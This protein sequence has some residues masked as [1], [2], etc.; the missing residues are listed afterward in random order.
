VELIAPDAGKPAKRLVKALTNLQDGLG[1]YQD[2]NIARGVLRGL[3]ADSFHFGVLY[4]RQEQVGRE[5]LAGVPALAK[6]ARRR[7]VRRVF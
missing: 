7:R 3:G 6:A 2:S 1:D 4:G 5:A